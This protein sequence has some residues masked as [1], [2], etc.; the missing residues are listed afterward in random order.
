MAACLFMNPC[1][2]IWPTERSEDELLGSK[3]PRQEYVLPIHVLSEDEEVDHDVEEERQEITLESFQQFRSQQVS[4]EKAQEEEMRQVEQGNNQSKKHQRNRQAKEEL[5]RRNDKEDQQ[6]QQQERMKKAQTERRRLLEKQQKAEQEKKRTE[7]TSRQRFAERK[8]EAEEEQKRRLAAQQKA[9]QASALQEESQKRWQHSNQQRNYGYSGSAACAYNSWH[10]AASPQPP[11]R[12]Y[13]ATG[14]PTADQYMRQREAER[15]QQQQWQAHRTA[16]STQWGQGQTYRST[17]VN[18]QAQWQQH[19]GKHSEQQKSQTPNSTQS[20]SG[21]TKPTP[22]ATRVPPTPPQQQ[23]LPGDSKYV[24][25]ANAGQ[26]SIAT[27]KKSLMTTWALQPPMFQTLRAMD[28]LIP[29][30]HLAFPPAFGMARHPY[31]SKWKPI[32]RQSLMQSGVPD[33]EKLKRAMRKM[34]FFLHPDKLPTDLNEEQSFLCKTLW[35]VASDGWEHF[36]IGQH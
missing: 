17:T 11:V 24:V 5:I 7:A 32:P 33:K 29:S 22:A 12:Q 28:E 30:I 4:R 21:C 1:L 36:N 18:T 14:N 15:M 27:I 19:H 34:R 26:N 8:R 20:A 35:D 23:P 16:A 10:H 2:G 9:K 3:A 13:Q 6:R 31:F 25:A